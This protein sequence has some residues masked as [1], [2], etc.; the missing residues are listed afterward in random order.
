MTEFNELKQT[1]EYLKERDFPN[2]ELFA[3]H[4]QRI[5]DLAQQRLSGELISREELLEMLP[6]KKDRNAIATNPYRC[7]GFN[8]AIDEII[9][10][11]K[12]EK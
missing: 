11:V 7:D 6:K 9:E 1:V 5:F 4:I 3:V 10:K 12:G 2:N 8:Q